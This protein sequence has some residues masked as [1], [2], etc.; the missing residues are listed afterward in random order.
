MENYSIHKI[1]Q[2]RLFLVTRLYS[3]SSES[4]IRNLITV[5]EIFIQIL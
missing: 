3:E 1:S 4:R 5:K 2:L